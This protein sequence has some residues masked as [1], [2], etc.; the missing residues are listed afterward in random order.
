M[1]DWSF[2]D[3]VAYVAIFI[4]AIIVA[5]D[6][7]LKGAPDLASYLPGLHSQALAFAPVALMV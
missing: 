2:W 3:W 5:A 4:A 1:K 7:S 6:A